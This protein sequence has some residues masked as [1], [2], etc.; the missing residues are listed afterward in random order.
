MKKIILTL[1]IFCLV[2]GCSKKEE[3]EPKNNILIGTWIA[4]GT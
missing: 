4:D 1:M 2:V 3:D